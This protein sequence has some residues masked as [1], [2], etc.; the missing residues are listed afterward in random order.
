VLFTS[1]HLYRR[2]AA[3]PSVAWD[4]LQ[5]EHTNLT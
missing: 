3:V 2:L 4:F 5:Y 1:G